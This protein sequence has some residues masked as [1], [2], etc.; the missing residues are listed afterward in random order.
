MFNRDTFR[1]IGKTFNRFLSLFMIVMVSSAFMMGLFSNGTLLRESMDV[2]NDD[3]HLQ[4]IQLYSSY[5]FCDEDIEA[6]RKNEDVDRVFGSRFVDAYGESQS[7]YISVYRLEEL[8]R[9]VNEIQLL[10]GRMPQNSKEALFLGEGIESSDRLIGQKVRVYLNEEDISERLKN[11]TFTIVGTCKSPAYTSKIQ[12]SSTNENQDLDSI[13]YIPNDNFIFDYYTTIYLTLKGADE[14]MSFTDE[15]DDYIASKIGSIEATRNGQESY[16]R[17]KIYDENLAKLNDAR[18]TFYEEKA[19]GEQELSEAKQKLDDANIEL[20]V[21]QSLID[22][23][24]TSLEVSLQELE[25]A[26]KILKSS[27]AQVNEGIR[28]A[29]E[30]GGT[31]FDSLYTEVSAAY[32]SYIM[33]REASFDT[34]NYTGQIVEQLKKEKEENLKRIAAIDEE[35]AA[36]DPLAEDYV[37][38]VAALEVEKQ[39]LQIRNS[40][41]DETLKNYEDVTEDQPDTKQEMLDALDA[42]FNGSVENTYIQLRTLY[43]ARDKLKTSKAELEQGYRQVEAGQAAL[44]DA[45]RQLDAGK[46][47]YEAG[48]KEYNEGLMTFNDEIEKAQ[49]DLNKAQ[50]ELDALPSASWMILDRDSHY[51][52]YMY[53]NTISQMSAI[54]YAMPF[55]F[56][57]VAALVCMTTMTRLVDEQ[58]SQIGIFLALGF[59]EIQIIGKYVLYALLASLGGSALGI[60]GGQLIFPT[61]IYNTWRLMYDLPAM[62]FYFPLIYVVI[63]V[64]AFSL[65]MSAVTY[66]VV[67]S[68]LKE[69]P[70][71]LLRPKAPKSSKRVLLEKIDFIWRRLPFTSKITAR[72]IFRYKSRFLMTVIGVAGC[73]ALLVVGFGIKDSISDI[74]SIQ[75]GQIFAYD[76]QIDLENDHHLEENVK[77]LKDDLNNREV[78]PFMTYTTKAYLD[79]GDEGTM[80]VEV[81]DARESKQ[82]LNLRKTDRKTPIE[83]DN[84][85]VIISEKFAKN[86]KIKEGDYITVESQN[87]LKREVKVAR[88]CEF[89]F[90]HYMFIS[91]AYYEGTFSENVH[92]NSIAVSSDD[93]DSLKKDTAKLEDYNSTIDFS[94]LIAQFETMIKALNFIILVIILAAG[95]LALVVLINLIQVNIAERIREIATLKVLGFHDQ[96]VNSYIFKEVV[97]LS[98][99]GGILGFPL[100]VVEHHFI[101]NVINMDMMMFGMNIKPLS[102]MFAFII[103]LGFTLLVS[104]FMRRH[105]N[106]IAMVESLKS[107][108]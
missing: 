15:Y 56:Y 101:M 73:T 86:H 23:N 43:E 104:L 92:A 63:C 47:E 99:I 40:V 42:Q 91:Q 81:F 32:T 35:I 52:S 93:P 18:A 25:S 5:G 39:G 17:D 2:Y 78:V 6:L 44:A 38:T 83:L 30:A 85:G 69:M 97:L 9:N 60:V 88:I 89:Y 98:I 74:V 80:I 103:T 8:D 62:K 100:G 72:N 76:Y 105:L 70:S 95:S 36:L 41:I 53:K 24:R 45:Q 64:L 66:R 1:L 13:L 96:E 59:S 55:L 22:S 33:I 68:T 10:N 49:N 11:D 51:S 26:E 87:G 12:G 94:G 28:K 29:E 48:L 54:G 71:M 65:L 102:F 106:E 19:K 3:L 84:S 82:V 16:L 4:D 75:F 57:L 90:Q 20:I 50:E 108:E 61:V 58:R 14:T 67:K 31:D 46:R 79:G 34:G 21:S 107:V 37:Q 27:E 7:G 77:I